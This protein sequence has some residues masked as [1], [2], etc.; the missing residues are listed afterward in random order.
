MTTGNFSLILALGKFLGVVV[1]FLDSFIVEEEN[2]NLGFG[3]I[4]VL[5]IVLASFS[6]TRVVGIGSALRAQRDVAEKKLVALYVAREALDQTGIAARN[7]YVYKADAD[8]SRELTILDSQKLIYLEQLTKLDKEFGD[9]AQYAK[10][11]NGMKTMARELERPRQYRE[12]GQMDEFA[13]FLVDDCSPLRRRIVADIAVLLNSV[14]KQNNAAS[15]LA[16]A[17]EHSAI[18]L[19]G[20]VSGA[21]LFIAILVASMISRALYRQLGGDPAGAVRAAVSIAQGDLQ[22][23]VEAAG[24]HPRSLMSAMKTMHDNLHVIVSKVRGG[25]EN[26]NVA[27]SEIASGNLDLSSRTEAQA[28]ALE[29]VSASMKALLNSVSQNASDADSACAIAANATAVSEEGGRVV[30]KVVQTMAEINASS[31]NIAEIVSVID[32]IAFQTNILALNAAVEAARAGEQGRGFAVVASEVRN[33]AQRSAAAAREVKVLIADSVQKVSDGTTLVELAGSTMNS[34]VA[35]I[36]RVSGLMSHIS[37]AA[38][39]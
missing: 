19:I 4:V 26:I 12:S 20:T 1:S 21:T 28:A 29:N 3:I 8:A 7:A 35:E 9:D 27:S 30:A 36:Q 23:D 6:V 34:V 5:L 10:V 14:E 11:R 15:D 38:M 2:W 22:A 18:I 32:S 17:H 37:L 25:S 33:L 16:L 13:R 39:S 31:Q 24:A